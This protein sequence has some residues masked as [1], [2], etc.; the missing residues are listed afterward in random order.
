M[1]KKKRPVQ[2]PLKEIHI[3][4]GAEGRKERP[5]IATI[6]SQALKDC[7]E[8]SYRGV[9]IKYGPSL[10]HNATM[11]ALTVIILDAPKQKK[12]AI[13]NQDGGIIAP[14]PKKR[15]DDD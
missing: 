10:L 4:P 3:R 8:A 7:R 15:K 11:V 13:V 2:A 6:V 12:K 14:P 5:Q 9:R 1:A